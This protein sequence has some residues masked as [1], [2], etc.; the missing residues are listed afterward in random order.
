MSTVQKQR[1]V[2]EQH[3]VNCIYCVGQKK[4]MDASGAMRRCFACNGTGRHSLNRY[5]IQIRLQGLLEERP[6]PAHQN[7]SWRRWEQPF[8]WFDSF[9]IEELNLDGSMVIR[10]KVP[11]RFINISFT[12]P[13]QEEQGE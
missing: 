8:S 4:L 13:L 2:A 7:R 11:L 1:R 3:L 6:L 10:L 9:E 12:I 5:D